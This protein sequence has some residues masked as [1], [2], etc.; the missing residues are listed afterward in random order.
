MP[1]DWSKVIE[2]YGNGSNVP[3]ITGG[4][5]LHVAGVDETAI[6]IDSPIWSATLQREHLEKAV[7][8]IDDGLIAT[9]PGLFVEDYMLYVSIQR[10]TS[11]AHIMR[12]LGFLDETET[13]SIRC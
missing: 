11:V 6:Y 12:D 10:A 7:R 3:T 4:K 9:D 8:L 1:L 2:K 13:F 5:F